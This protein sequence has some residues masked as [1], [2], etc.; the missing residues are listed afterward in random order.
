MCNII[1]TDLKPE[2]VLICLTEEEVDQIARENR[3]KH[4]KNDQKH[5]K[6]DRNIA[7]LA[8]GNAFKNMITGEKPPPSTAL[9]SKPV[10]LKAIDPEKPLTYDNCE[11]FTLTTYAEIIPGYADFNKNKKKKL[12]K[13]NQDEL[14]KINLDRFEEFMTQNQAAMEE[15]KKTAPPSPK[16]DDEAEVLE[17][18]KKTA[19]NPDGEEP[20]KVNGKGPK[21]DEKVKLKICDLGNG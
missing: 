6:K 14:E 13:K 9:T 21:I 7:Q 8:L 10:V 16:E 19:E 20:K 5:L 4:N 18:G 12:R 17:E 11:N 1:H 3:L 2:N 15:A